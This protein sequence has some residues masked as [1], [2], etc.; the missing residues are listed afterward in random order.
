MGGRGLVRPYYEHAGITI[1][2]G[3]CRDVLPH[4][5]AVD[6]VLTDPPYAVSVEGAVH[7]GQPGQGSRY[8]DFFPGDTDWPR[9][10]QTVREAMGLAV[11]RLA[12]HGSVYAW[13][14]H[15]QFGPLVE[16]F[17]GA[18]FKTRF[19][20]WSKLC[21]PPPP[22]GAGW[23][24]G[25]E[26]CVYA[27]R[28]GRRWMHRSADTPRSNV[29]V[30]DGYRHGNAGKLPHPTQKPPE[31]I[32]PLVLASSQPGDM[33]LDPFA[34]SGTTLRVAK[35]LGRRAVGI[36]IEERYC[37]VAAKRL[38]QEVLPFGGVG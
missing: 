35:D 29:F 32:T 33:I 37:E 17:E 13:C 9:M 28:S 38:A 30:A 31:V 21:P 25:A 10:V 1:Y 36:E 3:D 16:D 4:L 11:E 2:H 6:L 12:L 34:G 27:Y 19:L 14:G 22:P 24:S 26:L 23:P 15:R 18:G 20:V 8:L 7:V 5:G